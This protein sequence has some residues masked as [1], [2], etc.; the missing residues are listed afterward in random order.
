MSLT[1]DIKYISLISSRLDK[2]S[3]KKDY[4]Y[5]FRCPYCGDSQ[6]NKNKARGYFYK[7]K[8]GMNFKCHNCNHGTTVEKFVKF[9][10]PQL[11][12]EYVMERWSN[13][14]KRPT[15]DNPSYDS[16]PVIFRSIKCIKFT[17]SSKPE[18]VPIFPPYIQN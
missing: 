5:N 9:I 2:F 10:D 4:L 7:S 12:R 18:P 11:H 14:S 13:G 6:K 17:N 8:S 3:R 15:N 1:I 16:K